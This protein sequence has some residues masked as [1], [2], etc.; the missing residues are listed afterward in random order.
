MLFFRN[1]GPETYA[2]LPD[3]KKQEYLSKW[4]AW[5][6]G[7]AKEGKAVEGSPLVLSTR[8]VSGT[9]G[10]RVIDGPFVEGKEI[11]GGYVKLLAASLDEATAAAQRH[12][13]LE[14]GM[15]IEVRQEVDFCEL[16]MGA[17]GSSA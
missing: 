14:Y 1:S 12:P 2:H 5:Y 15:V 6:D 11:V 7:L 9:G 3:E 4:N 13:G 17:R 16:G 8:L 10:T